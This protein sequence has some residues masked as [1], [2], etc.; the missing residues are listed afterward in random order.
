MAQQ[1]QPNASIKIRVQPGASRNQILGYRGDTLRMR[2]SAP[3]EGGRANE[4]VISL[5]AEA[6]DV[7]KSRVTIVRGHSSKE[8]LI[9]VE[10]L[11]QEKAQRRLKTPAGY[12]GGA[13]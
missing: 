4:A 9:R 11:S 8:K 12:S 1:S 13:A 5:L 2:V 3:P 7:A 6:L 10:S